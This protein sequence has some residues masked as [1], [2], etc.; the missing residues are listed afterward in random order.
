MR[1]NLK[2]EACGAVYHGDT[3]DPKYRQLFNDFAN[4]I[5]DAFDWSPSKEGGD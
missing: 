4:D 1:K 5:Q 2:C 3:L